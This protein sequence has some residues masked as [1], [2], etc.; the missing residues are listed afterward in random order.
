MVYILKFQRCSRRNMGMDKSFPVTLYMDC[1]YLFM[2]EFK[3]IHISKWGPCRM[4]KK[5]ADDTFM[6]VC[7]AQSVIYNV[8]FTRP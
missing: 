4:T 1:A 6:E 5:T 3:L 8:A 7:R 2:L